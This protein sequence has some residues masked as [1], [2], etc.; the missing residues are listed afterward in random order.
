MSEAK[1]YL[2]KDG[3]LMSEIGIDQA[4][5]VKE[6]ARGAGFENIS[7]K[8]DYAGIDRIMTILQ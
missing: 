3:L 5:A 4:E 8:K 6:I 1:N 7:L 2:K